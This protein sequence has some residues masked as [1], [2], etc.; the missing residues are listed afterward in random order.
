MTARTEPISLAERRAARIASLPNAITADALRKQAVGRMRWTLTQLVEA[1]L[2]VMQ[3]YLEL[4]AWVDGPKAA[5]EL[6]I[7]LLEYAVPK[8]TRAEVAVE[9]GDKSGTAQL[10]MA[11]L[12]Q[13]IREGRAQVIEGECE[14][15]DE[16]TT[17]NPV[18]DLI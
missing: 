8:L 1:N 15:V 5:L 10:T 18:A 7:K 12:Q 11:E 13:I 14:H 6:F 17:T 3:D 9:A 16:R 2:P 4:V